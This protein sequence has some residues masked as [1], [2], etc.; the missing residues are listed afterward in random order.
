MEKTFREIEWE[1][2]DIIYEEKRDSYGV[3]T[4]Q[5]DKTKLYNNILFIVIDLKY[6][7]SKPIVYMKE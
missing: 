5:N 2:G 1:I 3:I 6:T 4:N 7:P